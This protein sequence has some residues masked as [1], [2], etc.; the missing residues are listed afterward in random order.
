MVCHVPVCALGA[1]VWIWTILHKPEKLLLLVTS[2]LQPSYPCTLYPSLLC[3][4]W[5]PSVVGV[6]QNALAEVCSVLRHQRAGSARSMPAAFSQGCILHLSHWLVPSLVPVC[7]SLGK[8]LGASLPNLSFLC[9]ISSVIPSNEETWLILL[10][11]LSAPHSLY[12]CSP[13][14]SALLGQIQ[15]FSL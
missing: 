11:E 5:S 13:I 3:V 6:P 2:I 9:S 7:D 10:C 1:C 8:P 12:R 14:V 4:R 15:G